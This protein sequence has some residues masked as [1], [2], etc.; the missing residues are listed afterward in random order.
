VFPLFSI[1]APYTMGIIADKLG[2]FKVY[3]QILRIL[4]SYITVR[5]TTFRFTFNSLKGVHQTF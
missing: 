1:L 5:I 2:N 3:K 4:K